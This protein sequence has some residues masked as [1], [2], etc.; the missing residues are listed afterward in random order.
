MSGPAGPAEVAGAVERRG[1]WPPPADG[2]D[3]TRRGEVRRQA[4]TDRIW[5]IAL[6]RFRHHVH[7]AGRPATRSDP[8]RGTR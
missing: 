7:T 6:R 5:L 4:T 1:S 3:P 8:T 2:S